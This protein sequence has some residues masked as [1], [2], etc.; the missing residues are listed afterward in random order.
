MSF[1]G[2]L[3][4]PWWGYVLFT[5]IS[6][7][8]TMICVTVFLHRSQAHRALDLHPIVSHFFRFWLW[9]T[10]GM[11]TKEW[12][13]VHRKHHAKCE[14]EDDPHSPQVE[15]LNTVLWQ[16]AELYRAEKKIPE[17][18][19]KYGKG[20]PDDWLE[21]HVY[22]T[23]FL[24]GKLGVIMLLYIDLLLLGGPGLIVWGIQ[25][26][27]TPF[28]AAGIV[29]GIG[30]YF[31][32]RNFE[33]PDA[34]TNIVPWGIF[35]AGEELHNNHH[36]YGTSAKLSVKWWEFDIGWAYIKTLS[37]LGLA[38]VKRL[39]PTTK[40]IKNKHEVDMDTLKA[41]I[42]NRLQLLTCYMHEVV[43]PVFK[44]ER[45]NT[46][47]NNKYRSL[48]AKTKSLLRRNDAL[49]K[50]EEMSH[51]EQALAN[52]RALT[53]VYE[54]RTRLQEIWN[55][56]AASNHELLQALRNWCVEAEQ[57][58]IKQLQ[59]FVSYVRSYHLKEA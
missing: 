33:C 45:K 49:I 24:R 16:G 47:D 38:K 55:R 25:M 59:E 39:H 12:V 48:C 10:T 13:A 7:H 15:G 51:I 50:P 1:Y 11:K 43:M 56:T 46:W 34:A 28:F 52:S 53:V 36:T 44:T 31:G 35:I 17:T 57:S 4:L 6:T 41:I 8:I 14:T 26:A 2:L 32:Y 18:L 19:E 40:T 5:L 23:P 21:R 42:N 3:N 22:S 54:Y 29:N 30:H 37:I 20:T 27:W 9:L 58:G